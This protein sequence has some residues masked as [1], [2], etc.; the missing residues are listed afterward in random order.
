MKFMKQ[1]FSCG[2]KVKTLYD[3]IC[4]SCL[5]EQFPPIKEVKPLNFKI[6]NFSKKISYN[7]HFYEPEKIIDMLPDIVFKNVILND[8]YKLNSIQIDNIEID[9]HKFGFDIE[10]DC[11]IIR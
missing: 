4:E 1:C 7:N 10:V 3:G 9:G 2:A 8:H 11:E 5:K 6:C